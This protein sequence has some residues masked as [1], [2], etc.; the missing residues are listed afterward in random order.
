M[1]WVALHFPNLPLEIFTRGAPTSDRLI[2]SEGH[3]QERRVLRA[4]A[5]AAHF[6]IATGM[7]VSA[8]L[9]LACELVVMARDGRAEHHAIERLA[10]WAGQFSSL[11]HMVAPHTLL[12]EAG[13]SL[14][15][16]RDLDSLLTQIE[17]GIAALGYTAQFA[18]APTRLAAT[19][20]VRAGRNVPIINAA[21][22]VSAL[23][24]IP[25]TA[26]ALAPAQ[27]TRLEGMGLKWVGDCLRLP[28]AGLAKRLGPEFVQQLDRALGR[29]PDPR[30]PFVPPPRFESRLELPGTVENVQGLTFAFH[31]LAIELCGALRARD[32]G[33][34]KLALTLLHHKIQA[35]VIELG[36]VAP[37]R[38]PKHLTDLFRER[39]ART[40]LPE[41]VQALMLRVP[42]F[43]PLGPRHPD[44]FGAHQAS[45]ESAAALIERLRARLGQEAVLR[46]GVVAE[47]RPER[48]YGHSGTKA[49]PVP[50]ARGE[51]P[52]WLLPEPVPLEQRGDQ[53]WMGSA[54]AL[55]SG[56]E[57]IESGWWDGNDIGRDY[58][59]ACNRAG[60]CYWIYR[61]LRSPRRWWLHGIFG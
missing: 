41:P 25:L 6:G 9:A 13:G 55:E 14:R 43:L 32:A 5:A 29:A 37:A 50:V 7:G 53:P 49:V 20:L 36:L 47:H 19:W 46:L 40:T 58:F 61:Q 28:R 10:A 2:V 26:L 30:A 51:R 11:V 48:A 4:N 21:R 22:L 60:E 17:R 34:M 57:R 38:D 31:R 1:L 33:A 24:D 23:S 52:L 8:A 45:E 39:L 16:F 18:V 35:T 42:S 3:G 27:L 59:V 44:L 56:A 54:L 15:L 12:L